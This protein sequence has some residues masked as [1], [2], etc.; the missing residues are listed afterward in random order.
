MLCECWWYKRRAYTFRFCDKCRKAYDREWFDLD[1]SK[2]VE[3]ARHNNC[4]DDC[5]GKEHKYNFTKRKCQKCGYECE[6]YYCNTPKLCSKCCLE[7]QCRFCLNSFPH[8][9]HPNRISI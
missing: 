3:P 7:T 1:L 9:V 5:Q 8:I 4:C 2:V 6:Y